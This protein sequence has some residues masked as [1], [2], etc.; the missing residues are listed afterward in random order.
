[1]DR[2]NGDK[3]LEAE[4]DLLNVIDAVTPVFDAYKQ[5]RH[6]D[7]EAVAIGGRAIQRK[8]HDAA[9]CRANREST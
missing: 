3:G 4:I 8:A 5:G 7:L 2:R 9:V 1:M 6:A